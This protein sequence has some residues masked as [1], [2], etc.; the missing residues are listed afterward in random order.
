V[1]LTD[2]K[3]RGDEP[4]ARVVA[5]ARIA[6][7]KTERPNLLIADLLPRRIPGKNLVLPAEY[8]TRIFSRSP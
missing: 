8:W 1:R 3:I 4:H 6:M 5:I 7:K 2:C